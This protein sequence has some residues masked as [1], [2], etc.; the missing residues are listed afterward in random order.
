M[1]DPLGPDWTIS[2]DIEKV[3]PEGNAAAVEPNG[4]FG[5]GA[6]TAECREVAADG[7]A[8]VLRLTCCPSAPSS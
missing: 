8:V 6:V 4:Y 7:V 1:R 3:S 5:E 2:K